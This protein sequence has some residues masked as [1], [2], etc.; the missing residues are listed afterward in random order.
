MNILPAIARWRARRATTAA[1]NSA[2]A[3][4]DHQRLVHAHITQ[5]LTRARGLRIWAAWQAAGHHAA[6]PPPQQAPQAAPTDGAA[7]GRLRELLA[8]IPRPVRRSAA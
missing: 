5:R 2:R 3:L 8:T 6:C 4:R 7:T 1:R